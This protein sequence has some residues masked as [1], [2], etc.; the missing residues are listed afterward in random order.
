MSESAGKRRKR[1]VD[2]LEGKSKPTCLIHGSGNSSYECNILGDFD[3]KYV[4]SR[5]NKDHGHDNVPRKQFNRQQENN[6]IINSKGDEIILHKNQKVSAEKKAHENVESDFDDNQ[7][8]QIN[9][10]SL[11]DTKKLEW[12]KRAFKCKVKNTYGIE[13]Q[14]GMTRMNDNEINNISEC[15]LLHDIINPPKRTKKLNSRYYP[16][17][18]GYMHTRKGK[19]NFKSFQVLLYRVY[20]ST[21]VMGRL[22]KKLYPKKYAA[23]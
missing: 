6:S 2:Y 4:K 1:Y 10:T 13:Y 12:F 21:I 16:I 23:M 3:S 7:L 22:V 9:N 15:N 20:S 14:N 17:L 18:N 19:A 11:D 8:Y 5:P